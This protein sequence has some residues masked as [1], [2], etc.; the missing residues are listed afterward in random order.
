MVDYFS[1]VKV[2][3]PCLA[4]YGSFTVSTIVRY[5]YCVPGLL[6]LVE[7]HFHRYISPRELGQRWHRYPVIVATVGEAL[8]GFKLLD[9]LL[10]DPTNGR[11]GSPLG[12]RPQVELD[13]SATT[14]PGLKLFPIPDHRFQGHSS[15]TRWIEQTPRFEPATLTSSGESQERRTN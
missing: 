1:R 15:R 2:N 5:M 8:S 7:G 3:R 12:R 14:G 11:V 6:P 13:V 9:K 4:Q 10:P